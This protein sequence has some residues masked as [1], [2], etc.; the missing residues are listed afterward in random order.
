MGEAAAVNL[1]ACVDGVAVCGPGLPD[2]TAAEPVLTGQASWQGGPLVLPAPQALPPAER[3][4]TGRA[5]RLAMLLG[6][7]A[8]HRA[9]IDLAQVATVFAASGADGDN[10]HALCE[11]LATAQ[12]EVSPTRFHN[13]VHNAAA[14]YWSIATH[15]MTAS[16]AL[17][18][19]DAS[20]AAGLLEAMA[21]LATTQQPVLLIVCDCDYPF[22]LREQ[23]PML[24]GFGVALLLAPACGSRSMVQLEVELAGAVP[25]ACRQAALEALRGQSPAARALPLLECIARRERA[26]VTLEY[27]GGSCL[28]STVTPC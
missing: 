15:A 14:G 6:E 25:D 28:R 8:A 16:T 17:A 23:R 9:G 20:F 24:E 4:R 10:C 5:V 1:I 13:S 19:Y 27:L 2:W 22:P 7:E 21:Q 3:R 11:A 18:A 26:A 12:R